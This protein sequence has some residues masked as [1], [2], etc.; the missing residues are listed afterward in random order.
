[1]IVFVPAAAGAATVI[2]PLVSPAI[3]TELIMRLL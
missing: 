2:L 3:I 1:V